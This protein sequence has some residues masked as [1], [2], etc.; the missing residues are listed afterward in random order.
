MDIYKSA[1]EYLRNTTS[2]QNWPE[3]QSILERAASGTPR[4]WRLPAI[5][6]EAVGGKIEQAIRAVA[7]IACLQTSIILVDDMLDSDPRGEYNRIGKAATANLALSLQ[8]IGIE[9]MAAGDCDHRARLAALDCLSRMMFRTGL[10]QNMD[11]L[12]PDSEDAY[13]EMVRTKSSPF[14]GAAIC[15]GALLGGASS[16]IALQLEEFGHV[17]GEIIQ[18]HD[19]LNDV[20]A[21]PANPDWIMGRSPLPILYAKSVNYP[22]RTRFLEL[23]EK[24]DDP[25]SLAEAHRILIRCGAISFTIDQLLRRIQIA[26]KLLNSIPLVRSEEIDGLLEDVIEPVRK[27]LSSIREEDAEGLLIPTTLT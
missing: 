14:F 19:D 13:W 6:C 7:T 20:M 2:L 22:Q 1:I 12:N 24:I 8:A 15:S 4:D 10:G 27:L 21:A 18:L 9:A 26:K 11:V 3:M 5:G 16:E 23:K 25:V 17:Y